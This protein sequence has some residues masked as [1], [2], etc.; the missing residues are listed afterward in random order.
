[1]EEELKE[2]VIGLAKS[3]FWKDRPL[4]F[5]IQ[6]DDWPE[7]MVFGGWNRVRWSLKFG[8]VIL[9]ESCNDEFIKNFNKVMGT[10]VPLHEERR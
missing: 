10:N 9:P 5:G 2:Y 8:F 4:D 1:M 6:V 3:L 7:R